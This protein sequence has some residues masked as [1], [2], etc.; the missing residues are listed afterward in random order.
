MIAF[1]WNQSDT[2]RGGSKMVR[3]KSKDRA[4]MGFETFNELVFIGANI[5]FIHEFDLDRAVAMFLK[6]G[7]KLPTDKGDEYS[8]VVERLRS[9][10][11]E[12]FMGKHRNDSSSGRALAPG[13]AASREHLGQ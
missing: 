9:R 1:K 4:S 11:S 12:T 3:A 10:E 13:R 2:E 8:K 7:H 5:C 6:A